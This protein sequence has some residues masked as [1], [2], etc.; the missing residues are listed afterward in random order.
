[1]TAPAVVAGPA[2]AAAAESSPLQVFVACAPWVIALPT[3]SVERL[4]LAEEAQLQTVAVVSEVSAHLGLLTSGRIAYSAWDLGTLLDLGA[5]SEA[6]VLLRIPRPHGPLALAL[7]TGACLSTGPL[8]SASLAVLPS[9]LASARPGVLSAAFQ[10]PNVGR[11]HAGSA[12]VGLALDLSRLWTEE[13][14]VAAE[15]ALRAHGMNA[16]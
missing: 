12:P 1:M 11:S 3:A 4:L 13:E 10:V 15:E 5:Q 7:R 2:R 16:Q 8:P 14:L 6:W 9:T